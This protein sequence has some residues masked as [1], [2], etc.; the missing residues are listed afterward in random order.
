MRLK[1]AGLDR[2]GTLGEWC[3]LQVALLAEFL[4]VR[5]RWWGAVLLRYGDRQIWPLIRPDHE[6]P[7]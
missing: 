5:F 3:R 2:K 6:P 7:F 4:G 1:Y